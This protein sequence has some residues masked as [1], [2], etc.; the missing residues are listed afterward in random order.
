M[1][2]LGHFNLILTVMEI[3]I[4]EL[5]NTFI[6]VLNSLTVF[7]TFCFDIFLRGKM[8]EAGSYLKIKEIDSCITALDN[9]RKWFNFGY[10]M[11]NLGISLCRFVHTV[12]K[13]HWRCDSNLSIQMSRMTNSKQQP[14]EAKWQ[15]KPKPLYLVKSS[16][17]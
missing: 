17:I 4:L 6:A 15:K 12:S 14:R 10:V 8:R 9:S 2:R 11:C 13:P 5:T 16:T 7:L 3:I 1:I